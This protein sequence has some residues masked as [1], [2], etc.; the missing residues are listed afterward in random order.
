[1]NIVK[2]NPPNILE[3][4]AVFPIDEHTVF[5]YGDTLYNPGGWD[6]SENLLVHEKVHQRQQG[7]DPEGWWEKYMVDEHFRLSQEI[8]A[9]R[10]QYQAFRKS[11]GQYSVLEKNRRQNEFLE[12]IAKDLSGPLYGNIISFEEAVAK[13]LSQA[14]QAKQDNDK[15]DYRR[16]VKEVD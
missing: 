4:K 16:D 9:Y 7:K 12:R 14:N 1:M 8:E 13:I 15:H 3:I 5:T 10:K 11:L 2:H 6:I